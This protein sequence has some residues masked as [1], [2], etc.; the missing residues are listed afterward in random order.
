MCAFRME[1]HRGVST[2]CP[3][4]TLAAFRRAVELGYHMIEIDPRFTADGVCVIHHDPTVNRTARTE[5]GASILEPT[6]VASLTLRQAK[7]LDYGIARGKQFRGERIVT[8][9]ELLAFAKEQGIS[10]K[11][12]N[13]LERFTPE[14]TEVFL[15]EIE[16]YAISRQIGFTCRT[17]A[18]LASLA[19]RM[20]GCELHYDGPLDTASLEA[21]SEG[22]K[23]HRLT[24]WVCYPAKNTEWFKGEKASPAL[25][26][27]VRA[28]GEVG[29][30]LLTDICQ[31][32]DAICNLKADIIETDGSIRPADVFEI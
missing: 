14:Q 5:D 27:R 16:S 24:V 17:P 30:W 12:D 31:L 9:G 18:V 21:V 7:A 11:F 20:P 4:S 3:E 28:Y 13:I 2:E 19:A 6:S 1:A 32:A 26:D 15:S 10:L 23:G 29:V 8:L 22:A 25:C